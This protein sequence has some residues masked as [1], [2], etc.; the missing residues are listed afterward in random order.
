MQA[1][2]EK[3]I[4]S[5]AKNLHCI[6]GLSTIRSLVKNKKSNGASTEPWDTPD[7]MGNSMD[8]ALP[9]DTEVRV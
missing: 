1:I 6:E 9:T 4:Q 2:L 5:S 7:R 8:S 3:S